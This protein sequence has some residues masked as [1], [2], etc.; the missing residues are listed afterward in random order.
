MAVPWTF[1]TIPN[2]QTIPLS[3][4]DDNFNYIENQI[5]GAGTAVLTI[6][7]G[8]TGLLPSTPTNGNVILSGVLNIANGGTGA[9]TLAGLQTNIFPPQGP[10]AGK[11]LT[12]DGTNISWATAGVGANLVVGGSSVTGG[13]PNNILFNNGGVLGELTPIGTGNVVL[14]SGFVGTGSVVRSAALDGTGDVVANTSPTITTP[15]LAQPVINQ[16]TSN[17]ILNVAPRE[18]QNSAIIAGNVLTID[19]NIGSV[20][21]VTLTANITSVVFTNVP[22]I[23]NSY[24]IILSFTGDGTARTITWPASVR[25]PNSTPPTP[26]ATAGKVDTYVLYTY[27]AGANWFAFVSGQNA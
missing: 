11:F 13:I 20:L 14:A 21:A 26:T 6:S 9:S 5:A 1:G 3:Y 8:A 16:G 17:Q 7:G 24:S 27:D 23:S 22:A 10:N 15:T 19:C 18:K 2:G 4:L 25:W 12:T